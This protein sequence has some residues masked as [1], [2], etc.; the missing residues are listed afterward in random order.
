M[1]KFKQFLFIS[2]YF[3]L[4][5]IV[6]DELDSPRPAHYKALVNTNSTTPSVL[7]TVEKRD[8]SAHLGVRAA[9]KMPDGMHFTDGVDSKV[10]VSLSDDGKKLA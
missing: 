6:G 3:Q 1:L 8:L 5:L 7:T 2:L 4:H 9:L 10:Q